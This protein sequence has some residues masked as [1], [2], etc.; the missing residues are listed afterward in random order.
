MEAL[1]RSNRTAYGAIPIMLQAVLLL[2][3]REQSE[4][5]K[6]RLSSTAS[7]DN[8]AINDAYRVHDLDRMC[9]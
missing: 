7:W 9:S 5:L 1:Q 8:E 4:A 3:S 2:C 6:N